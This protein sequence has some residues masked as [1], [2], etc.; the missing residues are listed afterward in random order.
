MFERNVDYL[1]YFHSWEDIIDPLTFIFA[2]NLSIP[3]LIQKD[4]ITP[5]TNSSS[6]GVLSIR[7]VSL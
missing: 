5:L 7:I 3:A 6:L 4:A 1:Y 2:H